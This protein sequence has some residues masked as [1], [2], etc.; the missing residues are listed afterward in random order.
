MK[1]YFNFTD[2]LIDRNYDV[3]LDIAK[4]IIQY[5]AEPI[6]KVSNKIGIP[7]FVSKN[8]CYRPKE[9]E[10]SKGRSGNSQ[11]TFQEKHKFGVGAADYTA[12]D[13]NILLDG[14]IKHTH[15]T[16]ICLYTKKNFIHCDY[17]NNN[18]QRQ[19]FEDSGSGWV[20]KSFIKEV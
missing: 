17:K 12:R 8:S 4:A 7:I 16:R 2:F 3:P 9:Y 18:S 19:Y 13:L 10:L 15:Y 11:H 1:N 20:F 5:H 14:L 6:N